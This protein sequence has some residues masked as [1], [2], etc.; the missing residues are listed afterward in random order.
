MLSVMSSARW[1]EIKPAFDYEVA[2]EPLAFQEVSQTGVYAVPL[3]TGNVVYFTVDYS[4]G[5]IVLEAMF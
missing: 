1:E 2:S 5:R 3:I 4:R